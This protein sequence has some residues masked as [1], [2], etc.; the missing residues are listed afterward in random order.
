M[1]DPYDL[2]EMTE[3]EKWRLLTAEVDGRVSVWWRRATIFL[4]AV[5]VGW[6]AGNLAGALAEW[7]AR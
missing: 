6:F 2:A 5:L 3:A 7:A 4:L 1:V